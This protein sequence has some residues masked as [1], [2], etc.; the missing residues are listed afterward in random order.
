[1]KYI[2]KD[3]QKNANKNKE[4]MIESI[5]SILKSYL[6]V[7]T[8]KDVDTASYILYTAFKEILNT[9][10]LFHDSVD[11]KKVEKELADMAYRYIFSNV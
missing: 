7:S 4:K 11:L 6:P 5:K 2:D 1:M 8:V 9:T 10:Y 3:I